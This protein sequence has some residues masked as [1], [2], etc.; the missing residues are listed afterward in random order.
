[1]EV[2]IPNPIILSYHKFVAEPE[3]YKFSRTFKQFYHDIRK[4]EF[5]T[6]T[7]D[8][9]RKCSIRACQMMQD[10]GIRAKLFICTS[11]VGSS[12][13]YCTWDDLRH[14]AIHHS[15]QNHSHIHCDLR[16]LTHDEILTNIDMANELIEKNIGL[17][18]KY[19]VAPY[20]YYD[21]NVDEAIKSSGLIALK[22]RLNMTNYYK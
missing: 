21:D 14:L 15:I 19:F 22:D 8:D 9:G 10:I 2:V 13:S 3:D 4:K 18:P 20:N 5:D 16:T 7:I 12:D 17:R 6:I 1:M 11:L